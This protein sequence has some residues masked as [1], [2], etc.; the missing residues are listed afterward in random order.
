[1]PY[2][3]VV[4]ASKID[5][6]SIIRLKQYLSLVGVN[7]LLSRESASAEPHRPSN[8]HLMKRYGSLYEQ[9]ARQAYQAGNILPMAAGLGTDHF[10]LMSQCASAGENIEH[11]M[12]NIEQFSKMT[13]EQGGF[14]F[15]ARVTSRHM[16]L[17]YT[18]LD[19]KARNL[20]EFVPYSK[21]S[22]LEVALSL[23]EWLAGRKLPVHAL[24]VRETRLTPRHRKKVRNLITD[25]IA[26]GQPNDSLLIDREM[27]KHPIVRDRPSVARMLEQPMFSLVS[28][29]SRSKSLSAVVRELLGYQY[30]S[31]QPV[32]PEAIA[33]LLSMTYS[34]FYRR[35]RAE[36]TSF[37][38]LNET[39][40]HQIALE[41]L[42]QDRT[43]VAEVAYALRY[44]NPSN[45][46]KAF[47]RWEGVT[48]SAYRDDQR[49]VSGFSG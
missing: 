11:A 5:A 42:E 37:S 6:D 48:P 19:E 15:S 24:Q 12:A 3:G 35:L 18:L 23:L 43:T 45:F 44:E 9:G 40:R 8:A 33:G 49:K 31:D 36:N 16:E 20:P 30:R 32:G 7:L 13:A 46:V 47:R 22:S 4:P 34:T 38:A 27:L 2:S 1:M 25:N 29:N 14:Y 39:V 21:T 41:I 26:T 17:S 10:R 28:A